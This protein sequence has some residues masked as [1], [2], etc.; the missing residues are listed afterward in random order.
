LKKLLTYADERSIEALRALANLSNSKEMRKAICGTDC[1]DAIVQLLSTPLMQVQAC[2]TIGNI[3][4]DDRS[5]LAVRNSGALERML[6]LMADSKTSF[7]INEKILWAISNS[8]IDDQTKEIIISQKNGLSSLVK[9]LQCGSEKL[10]SLVLDIVSSLSNR[11]FK[12]SS[13]LGDLNIMQILAELLTNCRQPHVK[14]KICWTI[15]RLTAGNTVNQDAFRKAGGIQEIGE[16]IESGEHLQPASWALFN[17]IVENEQNLEI[18]KQMD[19]IQ[20]LVQGL[21]DEKAGDIS[22]KLLAIFA[23]NEEQKRKIIDVV[24]RDVRTRK[25]SYLLN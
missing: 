16:L 4:M 22:R 7:D 19:L 10:I 14:D 11:N 15:T 18:T 5:V 1:V 24:V 6:D 21:Q 13:L 25:I 2:W 20:P 23:S 8:L 3:C 17:L 12:V 9:L